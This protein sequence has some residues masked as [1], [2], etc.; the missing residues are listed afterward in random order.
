MTWLALAL[1]VL[2][3]RDTV[4]MR[5]RLRALHVLPPDADA[6]VSGADDGVLVH[7]AGAGVDDATRCAVAAWA[8]AQALDV[9]DLVPRDLPAHAA[10]ALAQLVD[11]PSYR[12]SRL[13]PG[14]T[15]GH[16]L[17]L[18]SDV[19]ARAA[20]VPGAVPDVAALHARAAELK[21]FACTRTDIVVVP[22]LRARAARVTERGA[23]L[24]TIFAGFTPYVVSLQLGLLGALVVLAAWPG[25][26]VA[27][28]V[29]VA[30]FHLQPLLAVAGTPLRPRDLARFVLLRWP[31]ELAQCLATLRAPHPVAPPQD[32]ARA[33]YA[34]QVAAGTDDLFEPRRGTCPLCGHTT[35]AGHLDTV[36]L[37]Q[38][39]PGRF[40]LDRC[41]A[42]GHVFQNP[43]LNAAGLAFY[44]RDFYDGLGAGV[45][46]AIFGASPRL[47]LARASMVRAVCEPSH[48]LDVGAGHGHFCT[49]ARDLLPRTRFDGL[50]FGESIEA[51]AR[52]GWVDH[53]VRGLFVD[54]APT[55][56][57]RYDVVSMSHYLEHTPDPEAEI[58]AA[59]VALR[60]G[61]LLLI[62][63]PD[64]DSRLGRILGRWWLPW[65]QPQHLHFVS[66]PNLVRLLERHGF[67]PIAWHR[68]EAHLRVDLFGAT[69]LLLDHLAPPAA[70]WRPPPSALARAGRALV[71]A[72]APLPLALGAAADLALAPLARRAGWSNAYRVLARK[73]LVQ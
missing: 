46:D 21:R 10:L 57:A 19:S 30:L 15:A 22:G 66:A 13:A 17:W 34:A 68:G 47:Y 48:W 32:A 1:C 28:L 36:D 63:V 52:R 20:V 60:D 65:F 2:L 4:K 6:G 29:A 23:L 53:A 27:G 14:C 51:A 58:A 18:S 50:D 24:R 70:P 61:G 38:H 40:H 31:I 12:A 62:E 35:L 55:L 43:R 56:R 67:E 5:R 69:W 33:A 42:C 11:V 71:R 72:H 26:R 8:D 64:P 25:A 37:L 73:R 3:I 45:M 44:Y 7:V 59:A 16:A 49:V 41:A 9:V 54:A 39:K